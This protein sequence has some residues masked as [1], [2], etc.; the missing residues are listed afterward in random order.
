M[1]STVTQLGPLDVRVETGGV[2]KW[3]PRIFNTAG[4]YFTNTKQTQMW[5][6]LLTFIRNQPGI[7]TDLSTPEKEKLLRGVWGYD[8]SYILSNV[9]GPTPPP[10]VW[11]CQQ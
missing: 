3:E 7:T 1:L 4:Y 11:V 2:D 9:C 5:Y 6:E 10:G 8:K